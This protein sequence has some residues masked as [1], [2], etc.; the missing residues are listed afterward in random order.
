MSVVLGVII[1]VGEIVLVINLFKHI[2][3]ATIV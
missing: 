1:Q 3:D 2:L